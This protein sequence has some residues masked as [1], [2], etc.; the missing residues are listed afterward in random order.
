[1]YG[2]T[3][4]QDLVA[5]VGVAERVTAS[6][7]VPSVDEDSILAVVPASSILRSLGATCQRIIPRLNG[8]A[9]P[10]CAPSHAA[11]ELLF[12]LFEVQLKVRAARRRAETLSVDLVAAD[13]DHGQ[14]LDI[15][16][17]TNAVQSVTR[18]PIQGGGRITV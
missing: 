5:G 2:W 15:L 9:E 1:M 14:R 7:V 4:G 16:R 6:V 3:D 8:E 13:V 18:S 12:Q 10:S 11:N 17:R